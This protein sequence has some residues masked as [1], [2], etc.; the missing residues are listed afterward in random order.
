[1]ANSYPEQ[2]GEWVKKR[3]STKRDKNLV[4]F[5]AVK[6]DVQAALDAG[7]AVKTIWANMVDTQRIEFGY[8]TFLNHVNRLIR[9]PQAA[10]TT[11]TESTATANNATKSKTSKTQKTTTPP[12]SQAGFVFNPKLNKE[13]LF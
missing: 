5:L 10:R 7:Y 13:D 3:Q 12:S 8:D 1:M 6:N 9:R 2:L 4:A 11:E